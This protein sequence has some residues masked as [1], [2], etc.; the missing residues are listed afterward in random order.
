MRNSKIDNDKMMR[1]CRNY[2]NTKQINKQRAEMNAVKEAKQ[3]LNLC[4]KNFNVRAEYWEEFY[5][6]LLID[7]FRALDTYDK[8]TNVKL[9]GWVWRLCSQS[10]WRFIRDKQKEIEKQRNLTSIELL[11]F[12]LYN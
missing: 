12:N 11:E 7:F 8:N 1:I 2:T 10:A 9:F 3:F 6:F 4:L 5:S